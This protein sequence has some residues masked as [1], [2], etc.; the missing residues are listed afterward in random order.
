MCGIMVSGFAML[1]KEG[2]KGICTGYIM[3][4]VHIAQQ[5]HLVWVRS[6]NLAETRTTCSNLEKLWDWSLVSDQVWTCATQVTEVVIEHLRPRETVVIPFKITTAEN[7][8][9]ITIVKYP[10]VKVYFYVY[11]PNDIIITTILRIQLVEIMLHFRF[12]AAV[13]LRCRS[14]GKVNINTSIFET[15]YIMIKTHPSK[16]GAPFPCK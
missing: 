16:H 15:R 5:W 3:G 10:F 7:G 11:G 14:I 12:A 2:G 4:E 8:D 13:K 1:S 9:F 6:W